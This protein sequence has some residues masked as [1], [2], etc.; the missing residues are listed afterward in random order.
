MSK[1]TNG[2]SLEKLEQG[3][4]RS[5]VQRYR[6]CPFSP[7]WSKLATLFQ[8]APTPSQPKP[9]ENERS[10][11]YASEMDTIL[12]Q[13]LYPCFTDRVDPSLYYIVMVGIHD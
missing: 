12:Q 2:W 10:E 5:L 8:T 9:L 13:G 1:S 6:Q 3:E 7:F 11:R 4:K